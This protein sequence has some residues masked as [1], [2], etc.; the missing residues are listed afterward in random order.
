[1]SPSTK[2]FVKLFEL[3]RVEKQAMSIICPG[4]PYQETI[5]GVA[6]LSWAEWV[7]VRRD[8][9]IGITQITAYK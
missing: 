4:L 7:R 1:M 6:N 8:L 5:G 2:Y 3:V 9:N